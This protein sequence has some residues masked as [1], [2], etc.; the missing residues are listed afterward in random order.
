MLIYQLGCL[1]LTLKI[2]S[3]LINNVWT[4]IDIAGMERGKNDLFASI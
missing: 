1:L 4:K 2:K 3:L